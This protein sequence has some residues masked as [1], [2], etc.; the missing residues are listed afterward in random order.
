MSLR[1][2]TARCCTSFIQRREK[3]H[4][5]TSHTHSVIT[6]DSQL[7][8]HMLMASISCLTALLRFLAESSAHVM[9]FC[10]FH[11]VCVHFKCIDALQAT[12]VVVSEMGG[13]L[14]YFHMQQCSSL[15]VMSLRANM[16]TVS[17]NAPPTRLWFK[18][19]GSERQPIRRE[20]SPKPSAE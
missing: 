11:L 2:G 9:I 5:H 18:P 14:H 15:C 8:C 12:L 20:D 1:S 7:R 19:S 4:R 3:H 17:I 16:V 6:Q 13:C 10:T